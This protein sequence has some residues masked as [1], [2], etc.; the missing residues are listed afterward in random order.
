MSPCGS[1]CGDVLVAPRAVGVLRGDLAGLALERGGEEQ[2]LAVARDLLD[3]AVDD[4]PEAHVEHAVG[5]VEDE[6]LDVVE[7][8]G[9]A[10]R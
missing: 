8:D 7:A 2:R 6:D 5:L 9:A 4:G 10:A 1:T 3:D